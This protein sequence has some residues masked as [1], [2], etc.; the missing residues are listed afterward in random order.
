MIITRVP[1]IPIEMRQITTTLRVEEVWHEFDAG[2]HEEFG[3]RGE[4]RGGKNVAPDSLGIRRGIPGVSTRPITS[5]RGERCI[6]KS[7][8]RRLL[9]IRLKIVLPTGDVD[10]SRRCAVGR[11]VRGERGSDFY[12]F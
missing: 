6:A 2:L 5:T 9:L 4:R 8:I 12:G 10:F 1:L 7:R 11:E 3:V